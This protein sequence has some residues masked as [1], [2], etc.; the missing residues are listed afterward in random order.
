MAEYDVIVIGAGPAGEVAAGR[1]AEAGLEVAIVEEHLVGGECSYYACMPSK[2]LLRPAEVFAEVRRVPGAAEAVTGELDPEA[3][4][5]RRDEVIHDL[6]DSGQEDWLAD[7]GIELVRGEGRLDGERRV[8][9]GD[10]V[11]L[12]RRAVVIATGTGAFVPP[13]AGIEEVRTWNNR[14]ATTA[15]RVPESMIVLGGGPVGVEMAQAWTSFGSEVSLIE[16]ED[17]LLPTE[18]PFAGEELAEA[19][20]ELGVNLVLGTRASAARSRDG[21]VS[22]ELESGETLDAAELLVAV[23]RRPLTDDIGLETIGLEPGGFIEVDDGMRVSGR[24]DWLYA[25]GDVNGR[26]LLTHMGKYQGRIAGDNITGGDER[27]LID[28]RLSPRVV[29]TEPQVAA[30]GL[31]LAQARDQ[32]LNPVEVRWD[33]GRVAGASVLGRG[34]RGTAQLVVDPMRQVVVGATFIG[35]HAGEILHA[36]TIAIVA[37][38][39]LATLWHAVPSFPTVSEVWLRLL[40]AYRDQ[41]GTVFN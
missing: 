11:L 14:D 8:A 2:A 35:P 7:R 36:A 9:V 29:F 33:M 4:L 31:T 24:G 18:E 30:V 5:A 17:R 41:T 1:L 15:K 21:G 27:V 25:P 34:Y 16:A 39:P 28:S 32:G 20:R 3:A 37:E 23:G 19:L 13:I 40:E 6:D 10:Q 38:V 22:V 26:A 12:A